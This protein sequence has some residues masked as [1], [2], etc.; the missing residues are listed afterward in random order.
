M[1]VA[2][3]LHREREA[4]GSLLHGSVGRRLAGQS[5]AARLRP[6]RW[7]DGS[8][9][10]VECV[11]VSQPDRR[12]AH[13]RVALQDVGLAVMAQLGFVVEP[14]T[15]S[16]SRRHG[17]KLFGEFGRDFACADGKRVVVVGPTGSNGRSICDAWQIGQA[18]DGLGATL[19]LDLAEEGDTFARDARSPTWSDRGSPH[20][21]STR[22]RASP[23]RTASPGPATRLSPS[24]SPGIRSARRRI[25]S[26]R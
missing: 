14:I 16:H 8:R 13:V 21:L 18:M 11:A 1:A 4:R 5:H 3:R 19:G 23:S 15:A 22:S 10:P 7:P 26:L 9:L 2:R 24:W 12:W 17:N 25:R 20:A 6:R